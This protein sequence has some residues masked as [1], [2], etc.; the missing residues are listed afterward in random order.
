MSEQ[1][2]HEQEPGAEARRD[3][4]KRCGKYAIVTPPAV[5]LML[6]AASKPAEAGIYSTGGKKVRRKYNG[7][8]NGRKNGK[9]FLNGIL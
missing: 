8:K 4:L 7:R 2:K 3:F 1:T 5:S 9:N 6:S